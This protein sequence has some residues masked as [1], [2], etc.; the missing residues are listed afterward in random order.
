L[1]AFFSEFVSRFGYLA[2]AVFVTLEGLGLPL[3]GETAVVTAAA[4]ASQGKLNVVGVVIA[5]T[6]GSVLGGSGG[7]WL[8]RIG[9]RGLLVRYG[10]LIHLDADRLLR[11]EKYFERHGMKTVF[12][13]RFIALLRIFGSIFAGI[14]HM[15]FATFS[16]VNL[17]GG[18]IW[19]VTF[20]TLGY[21]F[22]KNLPL[23]DDYLFEVTVAVTVILVVAALVYWWRRRTTQNESS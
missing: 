14:A 12:F 8:G 21:L 13:A 9:G 22:G 10:H 4:F 17:L 3:P 5:A 20:S 15:P 19:A 7:Y 6:I 16:I 1:L 2:V 23:L 18:F 11:T